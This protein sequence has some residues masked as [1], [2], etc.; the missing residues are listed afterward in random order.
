VSEAQKKLEQLTLHYG[1]ASMYKTCDTIED[2]EASSNA[3]VL[4][5]HNFKDGEIIYLVINLEV[6]IL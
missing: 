4:E 5:G 1:V 6:I 3:L 2:L